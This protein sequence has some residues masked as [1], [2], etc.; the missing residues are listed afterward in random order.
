[1]TKMVADGSLEMVHR[2]LEGVEPGMVDSLFEGTCT[3]PHHLLGV[4]EEIVQG[5]KGLMVRAYR[6]DAS[7]AELVFQG[8]RPEPMEHLGKGLFACFLSGARFPFRYRLKFGFDNSASITIEDPY[9][10]LPTL[11]DLD[12]HLAGEGRHLRLYEKMGAHPRMVDG[13]SGTSFS[14]WA[15]NARRVSVIGDFNNWNGRIHSMRHM[16]ASG[17]WEI[18]IPGV[19]TGSLYKYEI[20]TSEGMLRIKSDPFALLMELRPQTA[21]VV[22]GLPG[23]S[24]RD[25]EWME[26]RKHRDLRRSPV[27]IYEL[28]LGSWMR[29]PEENGR[30]L[31]YQEIAPRLVAH[32]N[33][34]GFNFVEILPVSEHVYDPSWGYQ[35]TGYFAP[36]CR[37]GAPDDL[38][39]LV[40]LCH[41]NGIGVIMDWVPAHFPK[42]DF[43]LRRF[44]GS[45]LY[46]HED[47]RKGEHRDW[48]TLIFNYGRNEVRNFLLSNAFYW[49]E[50]F[51]IDGLRVDAVASMIYLDYSRSPGEWVPN[52]YGG[53]E[54]IEAIE[55]LKE[56]NKEVYANFP[57]AFTIAEE[58]TAFSGVT[59]PVHLGGLGFGYK[60]DMGWMNDTLSFFRKD[61]VHRKYH[62]ND[63]TFS[64]MYAYS[65][66]F[67]LPLSHDEVSQGKGSLYDKMPGDHWQRLAN[68]R[69]L[70][71][72]MFTHPGKKL[73]FMG[74]EFGQ[75]REW[76]FDKSLDW[77]EAGEPE[78]AGLQRF[79]QDLGNLYQREKALWA[80]ELE[81]AGFFWIDCNDAE[82]GTLSYIR[83]GDGEELLVV[84]NLTPVVRFGYRVGVSRPG[85]YRE[86]LNSDG[87]V[88]GGSNKG[89]GGWIDSRPI[90]RHGHAQSLELTLPPLAG[91]ILKRER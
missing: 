8:K 80:R 16:G 85:T 81:P 67:I 49:L 29:S 10:F 27:S 83:W 14:V 21:S 26:I 58:S 33:S 79:F 63:L 64:M 60:W 40:D 73:L 55:F 44:D 48:G 75:G 39:Y 18:F 91:L 69:L 59:R 17:I 23:Y 71:T 50:Q 51:H 35:V 46:E 45:A 7:N 9:R 41:Q 32:L 61:P 5:S 62:H 11:G 42:D 15:P 66:N 52:R 6:P 77:H 74:A 38:R 34:H 56:F 43:S 2:L 86:L 70:Y 57:G 87:E 4:H 36:S 22:Q 20:K 89:N 13:V 65:E 3:D 1:L 78:R 25:H 84:L 47:P 76:D 88:Y 54:N 82:N 90:P 30:W 28:H 53:N 72:Y 31:S 12:L 19:K 68:L 24:W 37:F